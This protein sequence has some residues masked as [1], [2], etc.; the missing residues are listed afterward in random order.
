MDRVQVCDPKTF[1]TLMCDVVH[2]SDRQVPATI[3]FPTGDKIESALLYGYWCALTICST[4]RFH[5]TI[6]R[7]WWKTALDLDDYNCFVDCIWARQ[8]VARLSVW[9][10]ESKTWRK[11][12]HLKMTFRLIFC[13]YTAPVYRYPCFSPFM[14][15]TTGRIVVTQIT[16]YML[17]QLT[18]ICESYINQ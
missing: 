15:P 18:L 12:E 5:N 3:K 1:L 6:C 11:A 4:M 16:R 13:I 2:S 8:V 10:S 7:L 14:E 9:D 17:L